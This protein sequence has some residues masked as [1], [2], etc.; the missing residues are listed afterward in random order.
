MISGPINPNITVGQAV[1][2][3]LEKH[4]NRIGQVVKLNVWRAVSCLLT[5]HLEHFQ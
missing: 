1:L 3:V 2:W 5:F 4:P